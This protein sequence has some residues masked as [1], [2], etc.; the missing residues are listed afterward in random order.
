MP[1]QETS[2]QKSIMQ[3]A[4][5]VFSK[6]G[7]AKATLDEIIKIADTGKGTLYKYYQNKDFLFYTL[8]SQRNTQ[9]L[10]SFAKQCHP[11]LDFAHRI[12]NYITILLNFILDNQ[13]LWHVL[14]FETTSC[15]NGWY[16]TWNKKTSSFQVAIKWGEPPTEEEVESKL[17]Y[18]N[19]IG[20]EIG[21]MEKILRDGESQ[22][23]L[24]PIKDPELVAANMFF[25]AVSMLSQREVDKQKIE[26]IVEAFYDRF[27]YGHVK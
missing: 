25:G 20:S 14:I 9:L 7:Y 17:K 22:G 4:E 3:A 12:K 13:V 24:K 26:E 5:Q 8:I 11:G 19:I 6:K 27:M 10:D 2:K 18:Y 21:A 16:M 15:I 23:L 1:A